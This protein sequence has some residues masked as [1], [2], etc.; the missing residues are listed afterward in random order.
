MVQAVSIPEPVAKLAAGRIHFVTDEFALVTN[1]KP[2][3]ARKN[4]CLTG[5]CFG[6]R[7][8]KLGNR[9]LWPV[10]DVA[11]LLSGGAQQ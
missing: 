2:Q 11:K 10:A 5:A 9:L 6:V 1:I 8:I 3:T 7:P 4:F